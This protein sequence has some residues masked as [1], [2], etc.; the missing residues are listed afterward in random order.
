MADIRPESALSKEFVLL[1]EELEV[2]DV[3]DAANSVNSELLLCKLEINI[4]CDPSDWI[5]Q[6]STRSEVDAASSNQVDAIL[7]EVEDIVGGRKKRPIP[8]WNRPW[9]AVRKWDDFT[10]SA[11][12]R[13]SGSWPLPC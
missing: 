10:V 13:L 8:Q 12:A 7:R 2:E 11:R 5:S 4:N 9:I 6:S 1:E 3:E